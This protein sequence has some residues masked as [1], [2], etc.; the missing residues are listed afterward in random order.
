MHFGSAAAGAADPAVVEVPLP[1]LDRRNLLETWRG[2]AAVERD[3]TAGIATV[4]TADHVLVHARASVGA[5]ADISEATRSLYLSLLGRVLELGYPRL[6]RV[7]NFI[8]DINLGTGDAE[9]YVRFNHGRA[10]ALE[11]LG[12]P[13]Q[14]P[15]ATC[16]GGAAGTAFIVAVL[17]SRAEPIA[18]ENP[19]Q[20][21]SY[22]Y[23][24]RYGPHPPTFARA[25]LLPD[26]TGGRL[27]ISGTAS[28]VGHESRHQGIGPQLTETLDNVEELMRAALLRLPGHAAG[29][30]CWRVYL[31]NPADLARVEPDIRRRL[32][33]EASVAFLHADICRRELLVEV[34]GFCEL[35]PARPPP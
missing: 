19:R 8:P 28:I 35:S 20:T 21:S 6:I 13:F 29:P 3:F 33:G 9:R 11:Q 27:F 34:E 31:R 16:V 26:R 22:H 23:P 2:P 7:W 24:R 17:A 5:D 30:G 18:I 32:G 14:Y 15:A 12:V 4:T 10:A 1:S 25:M